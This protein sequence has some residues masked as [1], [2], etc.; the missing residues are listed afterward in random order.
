MAGEIKVAREID[1]TLLSSKKVTMANRSQSTY[2]A[3]VN[4]S[5]RSANVWNVYLP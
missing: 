1:N 2:Q 4:P 3:P 5:L